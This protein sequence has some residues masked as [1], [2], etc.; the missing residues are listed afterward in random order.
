MSKD[1]QDDLT[2]RILHNTVGCLISKFHLRLLN[3]CLEV[4]ND[5]RTTTLESSL[6]GLKALLIDNGLNY[7][8]ISRELLRQENDS[9]SILRG[10][11]YQRYQYMPNRASFGTKPTVDDV[12]NMVWKQLQIPQQLRKTS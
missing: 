11:F 9:L 5:G 2:C 1:E 12:V 3:G 8:W 7:Q 6:D 4:V 10:A